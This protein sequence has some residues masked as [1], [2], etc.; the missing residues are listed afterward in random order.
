MKSVRFFQTDFAP[1]PQLADTINDPSFQ[2]PRP[3]RSTLRSSSATRR[4]NLSQTW[5][6][7]RL[8]QALV[9]RLALCGKKPKFRTCAFHDSANPELKEGVLLLKDGSTAC[10]QPKETENGKILTLKS[11]DNI[12]SSSIGLEHLDMRTLHAVLDTG[13]GP[14]LFVRTCFFLVEA[15][16]Q[17]PE[18]LYLSS[19]TQMDGLESCWGSFLFA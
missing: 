5:Q 14:I 10:P 17:T 18:R 19:V 2:Y 8:F 11:T 16:P 6:A 7:N 4:R 3:L 12:V 15:T 9:R 13:L 1:Q